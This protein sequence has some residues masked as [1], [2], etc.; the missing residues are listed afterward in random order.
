M[1]CILSNIEVKLK[2]DEYLFEVT[3]NSIITLKILKNCIISFVIYKN[4]KIKNYELRYSN[5]RK[6]IENDI[7][8]LN[9]DL[10]NGDNIKIIPKIDKMEKIEFK[11]MNVKIIPKINEQI[12]L[13][14]QP[15]LNNTKFIIVTNKRGIKIADNL[16]DILCKMNFFSEI[17]MGDEIPDEMITNNNNNDNE[18]FI[19]LFSQLHKK[20]PNRNKYIIYQLEQKTQNNIVDQKVLNNILN[21]LITWD[22]SN[23]NM[24]NFNNVHRNKIYFQPILIKP[25]IIDY[26]EETTYDILFFGFINKRRNNI[27][28]YL[29]TIYGNKLFKTSNL[30]DNQLYDVIKK[31]KII[32]N[33][34]AYEK[35]IL[36]T[37]RINEVLP[38][39]KIIISE[40]PSPNDYI[41]K[42][43]Y[44]NKI[45]FCDEINSDLSNINK[46]INKINFYLNENN[47]NNFLLNTKNNIKEIYNYSFDLLK[48]NVDI[49]LSLI[50]NLNNYNDLYN[51]IFISYE[52]TSKL[53][54]YIE[55]FNTNYSNDKINSLDKNKNIIPNY[56]DIDTFFYSDVNK[57]FNENDNYLLQHI[58]AIGLISGFLY[59]PKQF[60]NIFPSCKIVF[61]KIDNHL[62]VLND[63]KY[64][65]LNHF[66]ND[67]LYQKKAEWYFKQIT[68]IDNNI[69]EEELSIFVFIG[70]EHIGSILI[71]KIIEYKQI[72]KFNLAICFRNNDLYNNLITIIKN[73]FNNYAS[74]ISK[75]YGNDIIPTLMMYYQLKNK[76]SFYQ[77]MKLHTKSS[78]NK[79][80]DDLTSFL[81]TKNLSELL[82]FK[83]NESNCIGPNIY[84]KSDNFN[85]NI[86]NKYINKFDKSKY[87][88]GTMFLCENIIFDKIIEL[89]KLDYKM[90][91]NNN[92]YENNNINT[93]N[94]PIHALERMFGI[95]K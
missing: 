17:F 30:F 71:N 81:L 49:I 16:N 94:S 14:N 57:L 79:W 22:Y 93:N 51:D 77:I 87:I 72:Q 1:Q 32:I 10:M 11:I 45:L 69:S 12:V 46:L 58:Y 27:L 2:N 89:I 18:F 7:Y 53:K 13:L 70:N 59:H 73:N 8:I 62:Y 50:A 23:E 40:E 44:E 82:T 25:K 42:N 34:H 60:Y 41:N 55:M 43:F 76:I 28:N 24:R 63:N 65:L 91:F 56:F 80:F 35:S 92:L 21:S 78:D 64:F 48:K 84:Y 95:L 3:K 39:N 66:I 5:Y 29:S 86:L 26:K 85:K 75:E 52:P 31:S 9:E 20:M 67:S 19:I 83:I 4:K 61:N 90:Y 36:E 37:A 47:Y 54:N 68:I 6:K 74:F 38:Y 15:K 88:R 33:I